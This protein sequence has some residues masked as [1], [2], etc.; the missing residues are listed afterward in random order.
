[1]E[2]NQNAS[3]FITADRPNEIRIEPVFQCSGV[4]KCHIPGEVVLERHPDGLIVL[5]PI[6]VDEYDEYKESPISDLN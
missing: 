5:R 3:V 2:V 4:V 6:R 1:M